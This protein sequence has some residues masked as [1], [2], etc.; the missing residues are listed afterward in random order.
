MMKKY[1][2]GKVVTLPKLY[3]KYPRK[4]LEKLNK[5]KPNRYS[6]ILT[7]GGFKITKDPKRR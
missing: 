1:G 3:K 4:E 6:S 7:N 5:S 2:F